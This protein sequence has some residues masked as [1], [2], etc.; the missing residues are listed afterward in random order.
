[1]FY[2]KRQTTK[3][4]QANMN[5]LI[6]IEMQ[7]KSEMPNEQ[8]NEPLLSRTTSVGSNMPENISVSCIPG[9]PFDPEARAP[10]LK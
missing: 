2:K 4:D 10:R 8:T 9:K 7:N 1:M 6:N 5:P 3:T